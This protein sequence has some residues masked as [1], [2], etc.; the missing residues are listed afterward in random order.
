MKTKTRVISFG[1]ERWMA[2]KDKDS[3]GEGPEVRVPW[4]MMSMEDKLHILHGALFTMPGNR[5]EEK[6]KEFICWI[7]DIVKDHFE[8][9]SLPAH[10]YITEAPFQD[11]VRRGGSI[12]F[13]NSRQRLTKRSS[14]S[15]ASK[16][17]TWVRDFFAQ[18]LKQINGTLQRVTESFHERLKLY[19]RQEQIFAS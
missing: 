15:W 11:R 2:A 4:E 8:I 9:A 14:N 6:C 3:S 5:S 19:E 18:R 7:V 10:R 12:I 1:L 17:L 16:R 13:Q